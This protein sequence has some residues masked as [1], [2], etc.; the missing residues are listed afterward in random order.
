MGESAVRRMAVRMALT[1]MEAERPFHQTS[2]G[3]FTAKGPSGALLVV[4]RSY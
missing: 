3:R 1:R 2:I 4:T